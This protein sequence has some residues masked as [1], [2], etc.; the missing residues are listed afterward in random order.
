[1]Q[2]ILQAI[3]FC[4][5]FVASAWGQAS[6]IGLPTAGTTLQI[7][8]TFTFQVVRPNSI[9]GSTEVG[10]AIGILSC[11]V[12]Q[13][14]TCPSPAGQLGTILY[15]GPFAPERHEMA[16]IY[17]NFTFV[18]PTDAFLAPGRAQLA[19]ARLHLIGAGPSPILE[20]NNIT[21]TLSN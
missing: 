5:L 9:Q 14:P 13:T 7:G 4:L 1:M 18:V 15:T 16:M 2:L 6:H 19:V 20:L 17:E 12:S 21:V 3:T 10:I 8:Q 11:P